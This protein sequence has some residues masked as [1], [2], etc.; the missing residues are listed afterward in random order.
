MSSR[1]MS[2]TES[3]IADCCFGKHSAEPRH[4]H[5]TLHPRLSDPVLH[6]HLPD[7]QND[8]SEDF[9]Q[10]HFEIA[11]ISSLGTSTGLS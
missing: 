1:E 9:L 4:E 10:P 3:T 8:P 2:L 5:R 11:V 7:P 6:L